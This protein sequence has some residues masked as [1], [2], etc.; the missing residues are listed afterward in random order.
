MVDLAKLRKKSKKKSGAEELPAEKPP[1]VAEASP[2]PVVEVSAIPA[3]AP[4]PVAEA[5]ATARDER[6]SKLDRFMAEAGRK[7]DAVSAIAETGEVAGQS[8]LLTFVIAGESYAVAIDDI[9]EIVRP[10]QVTRIPNADPS[11]VGITSLR[12]TIVTL[13]DAHLKLRHRN[14]PEATDD[15]RVVV[16]DRSHEILGFTV[17][18]VLRVVRVAEDAIEPPPIIHASEQHDAIRGVF[19]VANALTILL[20]LDK[21]LDHKPL[22]YDDGKPAR[23]SAG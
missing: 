11:I 13:I 16:V 1:H 15:T 3:A 5:P 23:P 2:A 19:R 17:D 8:E 14:R 10:R 20:D 18:R 21:L 9:V 6:T 4:A 7:R 22:G 12:G